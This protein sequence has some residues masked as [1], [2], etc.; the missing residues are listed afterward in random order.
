MNCP[1]SHA[2]G[3]A[4]TCYLRHRCRCSDCRAGQAQRQAKRRKQIAYGTYTA[5]R[6]DAAPVRAHLEQLRAAGMGIRRIAE[7]HGIPTATLSNIVWGSK[8]R[9]GVHRRTARIGTSLA[10]RIMAIRP[11]LEVIAD[12]AIV[13]GRGTRRRL[14]ALA[15]MG[16]SGAELSRRLGIA[17][18]RMN[19][20][21]HADRVLAGTARTV[22]ALYAQLWDQ[23]PTAS[24]AYGRDMIARTVQRARTAGWVPPLGW[25]DIDEDEAPADAGAPID[26]DVIA[27]EL[28]VNGQHVTLTTAERHEAVRQLH[29]R[30]YYDRE[31]ARM[32][33]VNERTIL[34]DRHDL[35]LDPVAPAD[36]HGRTSTKALAA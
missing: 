10:A 6:V 33:L 5:G 2:H 30:G 24:N 26:I 21:S 9:Y 25:D 18:Y 27:V 13:D 34:R 8:D 3:T 4:S 23:R 35:D 15:C 12:G 14:Q 1:A 31:I 7:T 28:A 29:A 20:I 36:H 17:E 11:R 19:R 32:L 16:W 22:A